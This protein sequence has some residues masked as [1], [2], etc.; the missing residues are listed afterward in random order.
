M[1]KN[2]ITVI[3]PLNVFN[4]DVQTRL[5]EAMNSIVANENKSDA[6]VKTLLVCEPSIKKE[7]DSF[8]N[9]NKKKYKN[10]TILE[11]N[12]ATDFCSQINY[13]VDYVD[14]KWFSILEFDDVYTDCWFKSFEE[15]FYTKED[16]SLFLPINVQFEDGAP[17]IRQFCN[18]IVW[19]NEFSSEIGYIDFECLENYVG[20]NLTGGIFNTQDFIKIGKFKPSIKLAFNYEFLLRL[21][22]KKLKVFV[23]PKEGYIHCF[24]RKNSL[25]EEYSKSLTDKEIKQWFELAK[26]EYPYNEDRKTTINTK[27]EL[28]K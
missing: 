23:I 15:Y 5:T 24:N 18:E 3:I 12:G 9:S 25:T 4:D 10:Y 7:L 19:A 14:T 21:T 27:I 1:E 8:L 20:F 2:N 26:C 28:L 17:N 11:N 16:V 6:E 22:H 13:A